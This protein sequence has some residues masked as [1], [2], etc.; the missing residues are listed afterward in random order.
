MRVLVVQRAQLVGLTRADQHR[1][2]V[3]RS[4]IESS[5]PYVIICGSPL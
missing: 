3:V 2:H 4:R 1:A 5:V